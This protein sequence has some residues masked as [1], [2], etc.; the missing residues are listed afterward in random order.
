MATRTTRGG[1]VLPLPRLQ[2][3][4]RPWS[5][6][7]NACSRP[8]FAECAHER[9]CT[10]RES[11]VVC[12]ILRLPLRRASARIV[13]SSDIE[14]DV[15]SM[16][17]VLPT[18]PPQ[19]CGHVISLGRSQ[20]CANRLPDVQADSYAQLPLSS[21]TPQLNCSVGVRDVSSI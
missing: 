18:S 7:P 14:N 1:F 3:N 19:L 15:E 4:R 8:H 12:E 9:V 5:S 20:A 13:K 2:A 16:C 21:P 6:S 11:T 10:T 17:C